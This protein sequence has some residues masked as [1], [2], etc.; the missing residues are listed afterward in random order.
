[1]QFEFGKVGFVLAGDVLVNPEFVLIGRENIFANIGPGAREVGWTAG[2]GVP[3]FA[4]HAA[5]AG[6]GIVVEVGVA[7][8]PHADGRGVVE[9]PFEQVA[10]FGFAC[11]LR[12][13]P[14][15]EHASQGCAGFS[16]GVFGVEFVVVAKAFDGGQ[17][18]DAARDV[19]AP[20]RHALPGALQRGDESL[21]ASLAGEHGNGGFE[22][23][24]T[25]GV[26]DGRRLFP[27]GCVLLEI[28]SAQ[29]VDVPAQGR[30]PWFLCDVARR[31]LE[32]FE[33]G[34]G[35]EIFLFLLLHVFAA[36][37]HAEVL[38]Q[39]RE[40]EEGIAPALL[41]ELPRHFK[42][43]LMPG[44]LIQAQKRDLD[45]FVTWGMLRVL[46]AEVLHD[47]VGGAADDLE[48]VGATSRLVVRDARFDEMAVAVE[49]MLDLEIRPARVWEVDLVVGEEIAV[50]LLGAGE[51]GDERVDVRGQF[52]AGKRSENAGGRVQP[53]VRVRIGEEPALA[54]ALH[55][56][57]GNAEIFDAARSLELIPLMEDGAAR[58]D[59]ETVAPEPASDACG[60]DRLLLMNASGMSESRAMTEPTW[61]MIGTGTKPA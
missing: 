30:V 6:E 25:D 53:F 31:E 56:P 15:P 33:I 57:R 42:I 27:H 10:V 54:E 11:Q 47:A 51:E 38:F 20:R 44:D 60:H 34:M 50:R 35:G 19:H 17:G 18:T 52:G 22:I 59:V 3:G 7:I 14:I 58:V 41:D 9:L 16:V 55:L 61:K 49:F 39:E 36:R 43:W 37:L 1:M 29:R 32:W 8:H 26:T 13:L 4:R 28:F 23:R 12:H 48:Q 45:L 24:K 21:V 40:G 2:H 46:A 5:A